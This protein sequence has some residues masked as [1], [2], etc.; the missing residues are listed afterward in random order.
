[1]VLFSLS[2]CVISFTLIIF[3]F[4][5]SLFLS[6]FASL[7]ANDH[8]PAHHKSPLDLDSQENIYQSKL[9]QYS[10][11]SLDGEVA[12]PFPPLLGCAPSESSSSSPLL[13]DPRCAPA[14]LPRLA[15][16]KRRRRCLQAVLG[17]E[18]IGS[19]Q[20]LQ[21][22]SRRVPALPTSP[23]TV[24]STPPR[25]AVMAAGPKS[26][27]PHG[28]DPPPSTNRPPNPSAEVATC[29][30][31]CPPRAGGTPIDGPPPTRE[32]CRFCDSACSAVAA[33]SHTLPRI[34]M[35][36]WVLHRSMT[37]PPPPPTHPPTF[38]TPLPRKQAS[39]GL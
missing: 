30:L 34:E 33:S 9:G 12:S 31:V 24:P 6:V 35:T 36:Q 22:T 13:I 38:Q 7:L 4:L 20:S 25:A 19:A 11:H 16:A 39:W 18:T 27:R 15:V 8:T 17:N 3:N 28:A 29:A 32:A 10:E 2:T 14:A 37:R 26:G 23:L 1:M 21:I 5:L